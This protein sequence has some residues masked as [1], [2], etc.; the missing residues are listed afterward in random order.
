MNAVAKRTTSAAY[1]IEE[2]LAAA[3]RLLNKNFRLVP[4]EGFEPSTFDLKDRCSNQAELRRQLGDFGSRMTETMAHPDNR[5][6]GG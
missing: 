2:L 5:R 4:A 6:A 3:M 1:R